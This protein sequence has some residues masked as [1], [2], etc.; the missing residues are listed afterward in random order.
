METLNL[1][2]YANIVRI[3]VKPKLLDTLK[4]GANMRNLYKQQTN[5]NYDDNYDKYLEWL[6]ELK[7]FAETNEK[8]ILL[9]EEIAATKQE[10]YDRALNFKAEVYTRIVGYHREIKSWNKGKREEYKHRQSFVNE[11]KE[12][13]KQKTA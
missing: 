2:D 13:K 6:Y 9:I 7:H 5:K 1:S 3:P 12:I 11:I 4:K 8:K 10:I